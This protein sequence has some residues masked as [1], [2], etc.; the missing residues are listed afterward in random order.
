[1][2]KIIIYHYIPIIFLNKTA[3]KLKNKLEGHDISIRYC[4]GKELIMNNMSAVGVILKF[5]D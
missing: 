4:V 1:L 2:S 3:Q 5:E